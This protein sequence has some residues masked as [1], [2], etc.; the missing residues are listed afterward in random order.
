MSAL[1][2]G[3]SPSVENVAAIRATVIGYPT[4]RVTA[5]DPKAALVAAM[6]AAQSVGPDEGQEFLEIPILGAS[7]DSLMVVHGSSHGSDGRCFLQ[8]QVLNSH[9]GLFRF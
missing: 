5:T 9:A 7:V 3:A 6:R 8:I 1:Q 4:L 2:V